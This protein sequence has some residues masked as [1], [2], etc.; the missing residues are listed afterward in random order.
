MITERFKRFHELLM[1]HEK[2][3]KKIQEAAM[4]Q[5]DGN[6]ND[7]GDGKVNTTHKAII[8]HGPSM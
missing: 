1:K 2:R 5:K 6:V 7:G 4:T 3:H 8:D